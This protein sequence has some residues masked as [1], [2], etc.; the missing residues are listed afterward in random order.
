MT[1]KKQILLNLYE[2]H[3]K[4]T[5]AKAIIVSETVL[6][7]HLTKAALKGCC[8]QKNKI[9]VNTK[10]LKHIYDKKPAEEFNFIIDNLHTIIKY[11]DSVCKNK[12]P[13]R[14]QFCFIKNLKGNIYFCSLE[15]VKNELFVVT[16]FRVRKKNYLKNYELLWSWRDDTP[17]S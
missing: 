17:S 3:I 10:V 7:C 15:E 2:T 12:T 16:A 13:K 14:G 11:P 9:Y 5:S 6:I 8:F 4:G 1:K